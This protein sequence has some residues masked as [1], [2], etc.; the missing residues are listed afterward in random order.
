MSNKSRDTEIPSKSSSEVNERENTSAKKCNQ[1]ESSPIQTEPVEKESGSSQMSNAG[2]NQDPILKR[3]AELK[4]ILS[5]DGLEATLPRLRNLAYR[6]ANRMEVAVET[7]LHIM[8]ETLDL[9]SDVYKGL[10]RDVTSERK[11][12]KSL[13]QAQNSEQRAVF[14]GL[15]EIVKQENEPHFLISSDDG[16]ELLKSRELEEESVVAVPPPFSAIPYR[17]INVEINK[18]QMEVNVSE[19][20]DQL[21]DLMINQVTLPSEAHYHLCVVF[22]FFTYL[23]ELAEYFPYLWFFGLPER[24]KSRII[25]LMSHLSWRGIYTETLNSAFLLRYADRFKGTIAFDLYEVLSHAKRKGSHDIL[26]N[27]FQRGIRTPRVL[28]AQKAN[29]Q[30]TRYFSIAGPTI[31]ATNVEIPPTDPL[32]SRCIC[33]RMPEASRIYPRTPSPK[34]L[35]PLQAKLLAFRARY[36]LQPFPDTD[37]PVAGRLGDLLQPLLAVAKYLPAEASTQLRSLL[38]EMVED[39]RAAQLESLSGRIFDALS[40]MRDNF[41]RGRLRVQA[42]ADYVNKGLRVNERASVATIGSELKAMGFSKKKSNGY[43]HVIWDETLMSNLAQRFKT[44][45]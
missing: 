11:K 17:L 39:S 32:Y 2:I 3:I 1:R 14:Y 30:D 44:E 13:S 31:I 25:K 5:R 41:K 43:M 4:D 42:V 7:Y 35:E 36:F 12:N 29:F 19:L 16:V 33:I 18:S 27:R 8:K 20:Y 45:S 23:S 37:K 26:L 9:P 28:D 6:L 22:I 40:I 15:V 24:G 38:G 10:R 21:V 34:E